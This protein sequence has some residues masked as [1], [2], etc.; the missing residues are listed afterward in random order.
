MVIVINLIKLLFNNTFFFNS[1]A[2]IF[3]KFGKSLTLCLCGCGE[4]CKK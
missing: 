4:I 3:L 2:L 1:F